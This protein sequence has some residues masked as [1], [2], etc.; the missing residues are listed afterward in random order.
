MRRILILGGGFGGLAAAHRLRAGLDAADEV[1][2]VD[3]RAHFMMGFRKSWGLVGE[4]P[5]EAGQRPLSALDAFGI[6]FRQGTLTGLDPAGRAVEVDG[7]RIEADALV[8]AL[9]VELAPELVPGLPEFGF[10]VYD[11][12]AIARAAAALRDFRGGRVGLGIFGTPYKC[13]PA[14]FEMALLMHHAFKARAV[15][16]ALEV[17]SPLPLSMPILGEAGCNV[18]DSRLAEVG[19]GF[20]ANHK[21]TAVENGEVVFANGQRRAYDLLLAV[22]PHR[23]PAVVRESGLTRGG[24]WVPVD[25]RTLRTEFP[26][27]YAVGD[28]VDIKMANGKPLPKAGVFAEA[29]GRAA[30]EGILARLAGREPAERFEGNGGCFLETGPGEALMVTGE[31]LA[32]P[33]PQVRLTEPSRAYF[34]EKR[35]FEAERLKA[36]LA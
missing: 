21:A 3:R 30:A 16:A 23:A 12:Q 24:A 31:F 19:I 2:L 22:P 7:E 17:F 6:R 26:G 5:L 35:A 18:I 9:G 33:A 28:V 29:M 4:A 25:A 34:D 36:W 20:L 27:V 13:P 14:P 1:L 11:P 15:A 8:V 32:E 10:N